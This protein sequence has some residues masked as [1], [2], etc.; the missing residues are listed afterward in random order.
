MSRNSINVNLK[1]QS[2]NQISYISVGGYESKISHILMR[3]SKRESTSIHEV[4]GDAKDDA[5]DENTAT[6]MLFFTTIE[7]VFHS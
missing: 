6:D 7:V 3:Q 4:P 1:Y 5:D 2:I